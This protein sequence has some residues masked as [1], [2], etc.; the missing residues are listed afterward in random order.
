MA[1]DNF[2]V[3]GSGGDFGSYCS[4]HQQEMRQCIE[5][6]KNGDK[7]AG[8]VKTYANSGLK[9]SNYEIN[10][11]ASMG[12]YE[13]TLD[14]NK[15]RYNSFNTFRNLEGMDYFSSNITYIFFTKPQM[16]LMHAIYIGDDFIQSLQA[17]GAE[18]EGR[19]SR[20]ILSQLDGISS[21]NGGCFNFLLSNSAESFDL[22]DNMLKTTE[23]GETRLG[24]K[25]ILGDNAMESYNSGS[26][27]VEYTE[28]SDLSIIKMHKIWM[29]YIHLVKHN[30]ATPYTS[31]QTK[32]P[33]IFNLFQSDKW[34]S[35]DKKW[36]PEDIDF[37]K[38]K[39]IDY[40]CS[41]YYFKLAEDGQTI[42][43]WA[44]YTGVFPTNIPF[45][46]L[47]FAL[48]DNK[49]K[50]INVEYA[51]SFKEDMNTGILEE[52]RDLCRMS[53]WYYNENNAVTE[54]KDN[55]AKAVYINPELTKLIF[56]KN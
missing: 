11:K 3:T 54:M 31:K 17:S 14:P 9:S 13:N 47:S 33:N 5:D 16:N 29:D 48:G 8:E 35:Y 38:D 1:Q 41:V 2:D 32:T 19:T 52:F 37:V 36:I 53:N 39:K 23:I 43:Y 22:K 46:S 12:I 18:S 7:K 26:F 24:T 51:Y 49:L 28:Y 30:K 45:S 56:L 44:K 55:W 6:F 27:T 42:K 21:K 50:N 4:A 25:I 20:N 15:A 34:Y 40:A 10:A